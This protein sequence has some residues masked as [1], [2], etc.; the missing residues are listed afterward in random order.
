MKTDEKRIESQKRKWPSVQQTP[1]IPNQSELTNKKFIQNEHYDNN[2][3]KFAYEQSMGQ[4]NG[5][6]KQA[7]EVIDMEMSENI[8]YVNILY[9]EN[10]LTNIQEVLA[11]EPSYVSFETNWSNADILDLDQ[12]S[13]YYEAHAVA[14]GGE[15]SAEKMDQMHP[16]GA[17]PMPDQAQACHGGQHY[18][19]YAESHPSQMQA[20]TPSNTGEP[21]TFR[22]PQPKG[23]Q[24]QQMFE[25]GKFN[26]CLFCFVIR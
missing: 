24:D 7:G 2:Q 20:A 11:P 3:M 12:R 1:Y 18:S 14:E 8:A 6:Q 17:H 10:M 5:D 21:S 4:S 19:M 23:I 22:R 26:K 15:M 13:Y 16:Q 25:S 9:D